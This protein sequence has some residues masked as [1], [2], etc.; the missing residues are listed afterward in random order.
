MS[1]L[2]I[3]SRCLP[4]VC[5]A[6][7]DLLFFCSISLL[8]ASRSSF[9]CILFLYHGSTTCQTYNPHL[10]YLLQHIHLFECKFVSDGAV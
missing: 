9:Y 7:F 6:L 8:A 4:C 5:N 10:H 1:L 2:C 3:S